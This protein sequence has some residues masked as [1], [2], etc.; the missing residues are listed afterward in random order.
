MSEQKENLLRIQRRRSMVVNGKSISVS[1]VTPLLMRGRYPGFPY[2]AINVTPQMLSV[3]DY[4]FEKRTGKCDDLVLLH[5][6]LAY[7]AA[8]AL[9]LL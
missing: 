8:D 5:W 1:D 9:I 6:T 4:F 2:A 7:V 3:F